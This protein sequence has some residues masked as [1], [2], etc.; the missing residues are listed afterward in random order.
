MELIAQTIFRVPFNERKQYYEVHLHDVSPEV[1]AEWADTRWGFYWGYN[2]AKNRRIYS[3]FFGEIH[4]VS[5]RITH[6]SVVHE[7]DHLRWDWIRV[8]HI[9]P[10]PRN[11]ERLTSL[12]DELVRGFW[13]EYAKIK[14]S[15]K[16]RNPR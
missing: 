16:K 11:E 6:D 14:K 3:G 4:F 9:T 1:F 10:S 8:R 2:P 12:L 15:K 5:S 7:V 13:R